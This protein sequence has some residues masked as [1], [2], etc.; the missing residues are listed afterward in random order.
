[1]L[2]RIIF[3]ALFTT[4]LYTSSAQ[5]ARS[6]ADPNNNHGRINNGGNPNNGVN[7]NAQ[8]PFEGLWLIVAASVGV[9]IKKAYDQRKK[10]KTQV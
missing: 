2:S 4:T 5:P 8:A 1:M 3:L 6:P 10:F 7:K 9:G